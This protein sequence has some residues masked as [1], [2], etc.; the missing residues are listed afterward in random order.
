MKIINEEMQHVLQSIEE[1]VFHTD[2]KGCFQFLNRSWEEFSGYS[3]K[4]SLHKNALH[5]IS[6]HESHEMLRMIRQHID[7]HRENQNSKWISP[8]KRAMDTAL[9]GNEHQVE[10]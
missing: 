2:A 5:F 3:V 1:V 6:L 10:L 9:G 8:I 7:L 4:E